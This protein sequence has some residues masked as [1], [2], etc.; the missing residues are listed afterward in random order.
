MLTFVFTVG[1]EIVVEP[2]QVSMN[3]GDNVTLTCTYKKYVE[4]EDAEEEEE[5][6]DEEDEDASGSPSLT[7][8]YQDKTIPEDNKRHVFCTSDF[9][10]DV[11]IIYVSE[12][13]HGLIHVEIYSSREVLLTLSGVERKDAG[14]YSC[15]YNG[16]SAKK[17]IRFENVVEEHHPLD[18][19]PYVIGCTVV[20]TP[21]A[22]VSWRFKSLFIKKKSDLGFKKLSSGL[23]IAN[24]SAVHN[25]L[26]ECVGHVRKTGE[27]RSRAILLDVDCQRSQVKRAIVRNISVADVGRYFCVA[28]NKHGSARAV[29]SVKIRVD[30]A[31]REIRAEGF[32]IGH[33]GVITCESVGFD[34]PEMTLYKVEE[35]NELSRIPAE[36]TDLSLTERQLVSRFKSVNMDKDNGTYVCKAGNNW[37]E[38]NRTVESD[39]GMTP[40]ILTLKTEKVYK[41]PGQPLLLN[42]TAISRKLCVISWTRKL[43]REDDDDVIKEDG[44]SD[45]DVEKVGDSGDDDKF[46]RKPIVGNYGVCSRLLVVDED[47]IGNYT[48][49]V[50]NNK[51][52]ENVTFV[53]Y[54]AKKPYD[55]KSMAI[56]NV[57]ATSVTLELEESYQRGLPVEVIMVTLQPSGGEREVL[58]YTKLPHD[59]LKYKIT[60][61]NLS[62]S[63][64]YQVS[65]QPVNAFHVGPMKFVEFKTKELSRPDPVTIQQIKAAC[66]PPNEVTINWLAPYSSNLPIIK[67]TLK[68]RKVLPANSTAPNKWI[69]KETKDT[70]YLLSGLEESYKY[71]LL[72]HAVNKMGRSN[73]NPAYYFHTCRDD[74]VVAYGRPLHESSNSK[75]NYGILL[76][77]II[78]VVLLVCLVVD[79]VC[80]IFD[81]CGLTKAIYEATCKKNSKRTK[82]YNVNERQRLN[83]EKATTA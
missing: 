62:D 57:T 16:D 65:A 11:F 32:I 76:G 63:T 70:K 58:N 27:I 19:L 34:L 51:G 49:H 21:K 69:E 81:R 8:L 24:V 14:V 64:P 82:T 23:E 40:V 2:S 52:Y 79:V 5:E 28:S 53:L 7:W 74:D 1:D 12:Y 50:S 43:H 47:R 17:P 4:K 46:Y 22:L 3:A 33:D 13:D 39:V 41:H 67:Y 20:A 48:C 25:G 71:E 44:D 35:S 42:C 54:I 60:L 9:L 55:L 31:I 29:I 61:T 66:L 45:N 75:T 38:V 18:G 68:Y 10:F 15:V 30:A 73:D 77:I 37:N 72:V 83:E 59:N 80:C 26:Y 6:D 56:A 78:G 36:V